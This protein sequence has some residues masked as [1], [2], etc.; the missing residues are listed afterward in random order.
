MEAL[1]SST[2]RFEGCHQQHFHPR[3]QEV[4]NGPGMHVW[5][6][7]IGQFCKQC[8]SFPLPF[9]WLFLIYMTTPKCNIYYEIW[10]GC[11]PSGKRS[12]LWMNTSHRVKFK[13]LTRCKPLTNTGLWLYLVFLLLIL[14]QPHWPDFWSLNFWSVL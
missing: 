1:P 7:S 11:M 14:I 13:V 10:S 5:M 12:K 3:E 2:F 4:R 6:I 9:H 8:T